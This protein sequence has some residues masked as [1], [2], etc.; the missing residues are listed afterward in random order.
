MEEIFIDRMD[1]PYSGHT[2]YFGISR[3]RL[4]DIFWRCEER[5]GENWKSSGTKKFNQQSKG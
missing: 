2:G 5:S 4:A 3:P 1:C